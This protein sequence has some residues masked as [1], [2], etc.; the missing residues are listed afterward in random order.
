[1]NQILSY[2]KLLWLLSILLILSGCWNNIEVNNTVMAVGTGFDKEEEDFHIFVEVIKSV[3]GTDGPSVQSMVIEEKGPSMMEVAR[4]LIRSGK[5]RIVFTHNR[6]WLFSEKV[7]RDNIIAPMDILKRDQMFRLNSF[8]FITEDDPKVI[9]STP[10]LIENLV[11]TEL[12]SSMEFVKYTAEF[13]PMDL[14]SFK[15]AMASPIHSAVVPIINT[16]LKLTKI[17]GT[18]V[19]RGER[20][21]GKLTPEETKGLLWLRGEKQGGVLTT[22]IKGEAA[23]IEV[24]KVKARCIPSLEKSK[25][26][27]IYQI[28]LEGFLGDMPPSVIIDDSFIMEFEDQVEREMNRNMTKT[29]Q[30]LQKDL[31]TDVTEVGLHFYR[32]HPEEWSKVKNRWHEKIFAEANM[33]L[34]INVKITHKGLNNRSLGGKHTKPQYNPYLPR[35]D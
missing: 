20:M 18:A 31:K 27:V 30:K 23:S 21:V 34:D 22:K 33:E 35:K 25:L 9:L 13:L 7:A 4:K 3:T 24:K 2:F 32:K 16:H 28:D 19:F 15:E 29:L 11:S 5:R 26:K 6:V 1:L 10:T 12:A 8:I 17:D 14:E